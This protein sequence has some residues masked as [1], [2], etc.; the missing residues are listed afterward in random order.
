MNKNKT[1]KSLEITYSV[2]RCFHGNMEHNHEFMT[3]RKTVA[4][5]ILTKKLDHNLPAS[6]K[7]LNF[8]ESV[9]ISKGF[10]VQYPTV[11]TFIHR[12]ETISAPRHSSGLLYSS[13]G[14]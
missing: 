7:V 3:N 4:K 14:H 5:K 2:M 11:V 1:T 6:S 9:K 10:I 8:R 13:P 12:H